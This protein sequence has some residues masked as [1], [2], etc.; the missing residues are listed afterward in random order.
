MLRGFFYSVKNSLF[1]LLNKVGRSGVVQ[2][3]DV[4]R[5]VIKF[6]GYWDLFLFNF[7]E[8]EF[9]VYRINIVLFKDG[10]FLNVYIFYFYKYFLFFFRI[11][12]I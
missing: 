4:F 5:C 11:D 6:L 3:R 9:N 1:Y 12:Y 8:G 2:L 10:N 7:K